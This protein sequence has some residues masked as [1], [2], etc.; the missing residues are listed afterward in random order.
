MKRPSH[1]IP[2]PDNKP[3]V[4]G[5][6]TL[7]AGEIK[8][9]FETLES[10][11]SLPITGL[12][13]YELYTFAEPFLT[14]GKVIHTMYNGVLTKY[15]EPG[16]NSVDINKNPDCKKELEDLLGHIEELKH[17]KMKLAWLEDNK[18]GYMTC[19]F[20]HNLIIKE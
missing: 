10:L 9:I 5:P 13:K 17:S 15:M 14:R 3:K 4:K 20:E 11:L 8:V 2:G 16:K 7:T 12:N 1:I 19:L 6:N 18:V